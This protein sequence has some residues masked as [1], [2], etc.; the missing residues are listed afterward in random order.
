ME[1]KRAGGKAAGVAAQQVRWALLRGAGGQNMGKSR[2]C[3]STQGWEENHKVRSPESSLSSG[4]SK[5]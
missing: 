5:W 2:R 3:P 4:T 1:V